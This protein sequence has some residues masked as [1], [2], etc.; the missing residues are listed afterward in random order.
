[1]AEP[2]RVVALSQHVAS[3][4]TD[5]IALINRITGETRILA[6]NAMIEAARAGDAGRGF[7]VVAHEV[8]GVSE[9]ITGIAGQL[10]SELG[11]AI[12]ELTALGQSMV[13]QM[14]GERLSDLALNMIDIIDRNLYERSCD[15]RWWA[16][17]PAIVAAVAGAG[18]A[19]ADAGKRLAV[20]LNSY[21]VYLD[22]WIADLDGRVIANGRSER[23]GSAIGSSVADERWFTQ[24]LATRSG[25]DYAACDVAV[26]RCLGNAQVASYATAI[27]RDGAVDG[28]KLGVLGIFF[29]WQ[30]QAAAVVKGVRLTRE[31]EAR[32]VCL[33]IDAQHRVIA[34]SSEGHRLDDRFALAPGKGDV[35]YYRAKDGTQ[36][37]YALTPGYETYRGL[38]W[39][40][41]IVQKPMAISDNGGAAP[42]TTP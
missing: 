22:I 21:T 14:R 30:P 38:G 5:K 37:G 41:V 35:G 31:E 40:G 1:M 8:K 9:R 2:E 16:T 11:G 34:S 36:I 39:Y 15:V 3:I 23:Y 6:L 7:A 17:D 12:A 33:L 26:N 20:I 28:E 10:A 18:A 4:A 13:E 27:R 32:T 25:D 19:A 29:D 24:A 42:R